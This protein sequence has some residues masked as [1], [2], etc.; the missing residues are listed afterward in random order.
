VLQ[1]V[2]LMLSAIDV[3][4]RKLHVAGLKPLKEMSET[5]QFVSGG[6]FVHAQSFTGPVLGVFFRSPR[7]QTAADHK[8]DQDGKKYR[9][10]QV[11]RHAYSPSPALR[12]GSKTPAFALGKGLRD[13]PRRR[14]L[15]RIASAPLD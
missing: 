15:A 1:N 2:D 3:I 13:A 6:R 4:D 11:V 8:Y 9:Q 12:A 5:G 10:F 14:E 7:S